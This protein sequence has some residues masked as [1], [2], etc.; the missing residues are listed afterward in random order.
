MIALAGD[1]NFFRPGIWAGWTSV[2]VALLRRATGM[3]VRALLLI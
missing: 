3:E 2:F 1:L